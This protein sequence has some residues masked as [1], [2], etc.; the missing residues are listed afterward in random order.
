MAGGGGGGLGTPCSGL[1]GVAPPEK[2]PF[3][4]RSIIKGRA[5]CHFSK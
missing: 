2:V 4:A 1:R 3:A 5:N